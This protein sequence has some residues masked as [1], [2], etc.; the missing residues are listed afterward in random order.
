MNPMNDDHL[1]HLDGIVEGRILRG[2]P[3]NY[4][5]SIQYKGLAHRYDRNMASM[6]YEIK[7]ARALWDPELEGWRCPPGTRNGGDFTDRFGRNCGWGVTRRIANAITD[8]G[9]R[10]ENALE[11]RRIAKANRKGKPKKRRLGQ[12]AERISS[13]GR[14]VGTEPAEAGRRVVPRTTRTRRGEDGTPERM[15][16]AADEVLQGNFLEN[17]RKRRAARRA[18]REAEQAKRPKVQRGRRGR[19]IPERLERAADDVLSGNFLERRRKRRESDRRRRETAQ[20]G[21]TV[22]SGGN[23]RPSSPGRPA[24]STPRPRRTTG[25]RVDIGTRGSARRKEAEKALKDEKDINDD[26]WKSRLRGKEVNAKNISAYIAEREQRGDLTPA[27]LNTLRARERDH[28]ILSSGNAIE[29]LDELSPAARKRLAKRVDAADKKPTP[30]TPEPVAPPA[31]TPPAPPAPAPAP[32]P[33]RPTPSAPQTP[34]PPPPAPNRPTPPRPTPPAPQAPQ[35]PPPY[36]PLGPVDPKLTDISNDPKERRRIKQILD[37]QAKEIKRRLARNRKLLADDRNTSRRE[38][39][40]EI[41]SAQ[42]AIDRQTRIIADR[43]NTTYLRLEA[44]RTREEYLEHLQ[45]LRDIQEQIR[46]RDA[47]AQRRA[48]EE[49]AKR[50]RA[51]QAAREAERVAREAEA[52]AQNEPEPPTPEAPPATPRTPGTGRRTNTFGLDKDQMDQADRYV[53]SEKTSWKNQKN[54]INALLGRDGSRDE[55]NKLLERRIAEIEEAI[56]DFQADIDN[57]DADPSDRYLATRL[58]ASAEAH[59]DALRSLTKAPAAGPAPYVPAAPP[60]NPSPEPDPNNPDELIPNPKDRARLRSDFDERSKPI[61]ARRIK[62]IGDYLRDRYGKD[63]SPWN[64][65]AQNLTLDQMKDLIET[66][67]SGTTTEKAEAN[68]KLLEWAKRIYE[69]PE[70]EG[71]DGKK[72]R[73]VVAEGRGTVTNQIGISGSI[74]AMDAN[75][76]WRNIGS[77]TRYVAPSGTGLGLT[78]DTPTVIN[79]YLKI[80]STE[81]KNSGFASIFNPHAFTWMKAA[82]IEKAKVSADWDGKFVWGKL[83]FRQNSAQSKAIALKLEEEI[84]KIRAGGRSSVV[85]K[86]DAD[87]IAM[88]LDEARRKNY[89]VDAP[90]HPEYLLAMSNRD[91][92]NVKGWFTKNAAFTTGEFPFDEIPD[93]PRK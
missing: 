21:R 87:L 9:E 20:A 59:R 53:E 74:Q 33:S 7:R 6:S 34:Q 61:L 5:A 65:P 88:L 15:E 45:G 3:E 76:N 69:L 22:P 90:Q 66:A 31:P 55:G 26:F 13:R 82:G 44:Q 93:D 78:P 38:I 89:S 72:Y 27:Y 25:P 84:K 86:R 4:R 14:R 77:F 57:E 54:E 70:F 47:D 52:A 62:V 79:Q 16:R 10:L 43:S 18:Q 75:G 23:R 85:N 1:D 50:R 68:Q 35:P 2:S 41:D 29:R 37:A 39:D 63:D 24:P 48:Q 73:T 28:E 30:A 19:N 46:E 32:T 11:K 64:D 60:R 81:H 91:K 58:I 8:T 56:D 36:N 49:L 51:E 67:K 83:G 42:A 40:E 17:F 80:T 92:R 71:K 12:P